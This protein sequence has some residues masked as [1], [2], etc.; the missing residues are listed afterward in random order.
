MNKPL[1]RRMSP[2]G[3][4][5]DAFILFWTG[6]AAVE[7]AYPHIFVEDSEAVKI[8]R[9]A[10]FAACVFFLID[11]AWRYLSAAD[12]IGFWKWGIVDLISAIPFITVL[13]YGRIISAARIILSVC[14]SGKGLRFFLSKQGGLHTVACSHN[15][16][17]GNHF[18]FSDGVALRARGRVCEY[19]D[20]FWRFV[21]GCGNGEHS[22]IR[23][24]I[25]GYNKWKNCRN[26]FNDVRGRFVQPFGGSICRV[27]YKRGKERRH[28]RFWRRGCACK[29]TGVSAEAAKINCIVS[30]R[31]LL[32][33]IATL[34]RA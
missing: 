19:K 17:C 14:T 9:L 6:V 30:I 1:K 12:K 11:V 2:P 8:F 25:S 5:W 22:G 3:G 32:C 28:C 27:D 13:R 29:K 7:L 15:A 21:V 4:G 33:F 31:F 34:K 24:C 23:R 10:D 26:G 20:V 16:F 18:F